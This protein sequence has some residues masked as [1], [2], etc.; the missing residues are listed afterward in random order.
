MSGQKGGFPLTDC[1][2]TFSVHSYRYLSIFFPTPSTEACGN[3]CCQRHATEL[4]HSGSCY[5]PRMKRKRERQQ[6]TQM[7]EQI[8]ADF[9]KQ[10]DS[11]FKLNPD[12]MRDNRD[13]RG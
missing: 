1:E 11:F 2:K 6:E 8:Y 12:I 13:M 5:I 3:I 9:E 7:L 10:V 4:I